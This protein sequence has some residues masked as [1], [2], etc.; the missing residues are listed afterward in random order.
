MGDWIRREKRIQDR[1]SRLTGNGIAAG[2]IFQGLIDS[3]SGEHQSAKLSYSGGMSNIP[4]PMPFESSSSW[5][6]SIPNTGAAALLAYRGDTQEPTFIRYLNDEPSKR[7]SD[8]NGGLNLYR[9]LVSGEHEIHSSGNAQ[10]YYSQRPLLEQRGGVI[11]SWLDQDKAEAGQRAPIH[12]R[13]L[14]G[15]KSNAVGDE[16]RIGVVRRPKKL[17][18]ANAALLGTTTS[19][20]FYTY[21][22]PD[23]SLPG[24]VPAAFGLLSEA[25]G[26]ASEA[27]SAITGLYKIRPFAKEYLRVI[28]NDL[29]VGTGSAKVFLPPT[30]LVDIR[31]GQVFDDEGKQVTGESGAYLRAKHEYFTTLNDSTKM[32]IDDLGNIVWSLSLGATEGWLTKVPFGAWKLEAN[33]GIDMST[34]TSITLSSTLSTDISATTDISL[35]STLN[36]ALSAG[37]NYEV[38]ANGTWDGASKMD[39]SLKTDMNLNTEATMVYE[40]KGGVKMIL[41]APQVE[42][43]SSPSEPTVMGQQL[44][45]WL[46]T[47]CD[48]FTNN[49][50]N[51]GV[52]N[53]GAPVPL[54]P[55]IVTG[56]SQ[57]AAQI[58]LLTSKTITVTA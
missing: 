51:M 19:S 47:L 50:S 25:V 14:H 38:T 52:G 39:M 53:N 9:P 55:A 40:A 34:L 24:G 33:R 44:S 45:T 56:I 29:H 30:H 48:L 16:E 3:T 46:Q 27:A 15:Y 28:K 11:R 2:G 42:I 4:L 1:N 8:Y 23:F 18:L 31:E 37:L 22:Y 35:A 21:P 10:S 49:A 13:Q 41:N 12:T 54:N 6:R 58:Q 20:N 17:N 57:L 5:I 43:G 7:L 32:E 26:A 36:T